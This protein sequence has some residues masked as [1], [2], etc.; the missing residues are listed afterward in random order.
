MQSDGNLVVYDTDG[1]P[2][3]VGYPT[4]TSAQAPFYR[5]MACSSST[6]PQ[7]HRSGAAAA[8]VAAGEAVPGGSNVLCGEQWLNV[9]DSLY[10]ANG[11]FRLSYQDDGNLGVFTS[12]GTPV[13]GSGT[14]RELRQTTRRCRQTVTSSSTIPTVTPLWWSGTDGNYGAYF[15]LQRRWTIGHLQCR[16]ESL[17]VKQL[18]WRIG[19]GVWLAA[20][21]SAPAWAQT[22]RWTFEI[23]GGLAGGS[24]PM[25][26]T[27]QL[28][29]AGPLTLSTIVGWRTG[30]GF[31]YYWER[32]LVPESM[33]PRP[34][35]RCAAVGAA[36][37]DAD[38]VR[39]APV[40]RSRVW[41]SREPQA[42]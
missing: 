27:G 39:H 26:G 5:T 38:W 2:L 3:V 34:F 36:G 6:A 22:P 35:S 4:A 40:S 1:V 8:V 17:V 18:T 19:L 7:G 24:A 32:R 42:D 31:L 20:S 33:A 37:S 15:M 28:P 30:Y 10:S 13:W 14:L 41:L 25:Q 29:P 16:R 9:D 11:A 23:H 12:D 21:S